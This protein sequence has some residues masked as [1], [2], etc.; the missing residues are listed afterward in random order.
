MNIYKNLI[1]I[2]NKQTNEFEDKT[3]KISSVEYLNNRVIMVTYSGT[4]KVYKYN[5][6]NIRVFKDPEII[7]LENLI[8]YIDE[9]PIENVSSVLDFGEYIRIIDNNK[10][11]TT[12]HKSRVS[13][14]SS[15]L[16]FEKSKAIFDYFKELSKYLNVTEDGKKVLLDQYDKLTKVSEQSVLSTYLSGKS[17]ES[18]KN[19]DVPIFPFGM[20]LSQKK[21]VKTALES[22]I[23]IVEGPPGTGKTQTILNII[24]NVVMKGKTVAV[25][26]NNNSATSNVQEKLEKNGYG[27]ITALLGNSINKKDFFD[28]KQS[29]IPN[30]SD[31]SEEL[32]DIKLLSEELS[33][34]SETLEALLADQNQIAQLQEEVSKLKVEQTYFDKQFKGKYNYIPPSSY[35]FHKKWSSDSILDFITHFERIFLTGRE[36]KFMEKTFLFFRYGIYKLNLVA[37]N[38]KDV[39][40]SLKGDYYRIGIEEREKQISALKDNLKNKSYEGLMKDYTEVSTKLFK[41]SIHKRYSN[42]SRKIYTIKNYKHKFKNFI[43]DYPVILSTT[44]SILNSAPNNYLFDYLIID[45][46]SQVDLVTASLAL[47][48]C[49]NVVIVGDVKQLPQIVPT[50]IE[51]I[52]DKLFYK[53]NVSEAYNYKNNSIIASLNK[54]Y[55]EDLPKTLLREH[56]RCQ[57]KI[58]GFCNEKFYDNQLIIMTEEKQDDKP[59]KL[60]KTAPG[61][62]E[63]IDIQS[64][65][66][67]R[68]N[69]R[70]IE[71]IRDEIFAANKNKYNDLKNIGII[72]PYRRHVTE[73]KKRIK[74]PELEVDTVHKFQ[75]R[76]KDTI[77]FTTVA[78]EIT[79][80]IDDPNLINVAVS[81]AV[82]ELIIVTSN[83]LFKQHGTYIGDLIRYIEYNSLSSAII[84]SQKISVFDLLYSEYSKKLLKIMKSTKHVS[85][86]MSENLMYSVIEEVL[87]YPKF[88]SFKC[89][90]HVPLHSIIKD[91]SKLSE[92]ERR[93]AENPWTHVDFL[94]YNKLDKE[95][96]L[97]IEVDGVKYHQNNPK[98]LQ[99]DKLKD[100]ILKEN[101]LRIIRISTNESGEKEKLIEELDKIIKLSS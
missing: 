72:S 58:I 2:K 50:E 27:F 92:E 65:E 75:G 91:F 3:T 43:K 61:N 85:E 9:I 16:I 77:I 96:V 94:I 48:C 81:R 78:N 24:A 1:L 15:I 64:D 88:S 73:I 59:L 21:A 100:K 5:F 83:K 67:G 66:K 84:E 30:I 55:K 45:E 19:D 80:F 74:H 51:K 68:Y 26:S 44:H 33:R 86:Y 14:Q 46:A 17:L 87:S 31:W 4:N 97:A 39:I 35:S 25:V 99:R 95:P 89:V 22:T 54:L 52:S 10:N 12:Y 23:S 60:Y 70:Q 34:I 79:P 71:V 76:E 63:R 29:A 42:S 40:A 56:Y 11:T 36:E 32:E 47:S 98:Q 8:V 38:Q 90:I 57:P 53:L 41:A 49:K 13:F 7:N 82:K 69:V 6:V 18:R 28:N 20:N 62:H 93:F 37:K 101:Q